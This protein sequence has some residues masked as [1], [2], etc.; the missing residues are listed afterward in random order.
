MRYTLQYK[1]CLFTVEDETCHDSGGMTS[2]FTSSI[3]P[4]I[5]YDIGYYVEGPPFRIV[6]RDILKGHRIEIDTACLDLLIQMSQQDLAELNQLLTD[7]AKEYVL[8]INEAR[9]L[10]LEVPDV[11]CRPLYKV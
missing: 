5:E 2:F 6:Q 10:D 8:V 4:E 9:S 1:D 7:R 3:E 11:P